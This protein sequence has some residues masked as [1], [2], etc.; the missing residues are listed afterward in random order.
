[1]NGNHPVSVLNIGGNAS[2]IPKNSNDA[3]EGSKVK[4]S[5][6]AK[7]QGLSNEGN[8][9]YNTFLDAIKAKQKNF[10]GEEFE[11][12]LLKNIMDY[13]D[14]CGKN[15]RKEVVEYVTYRHELW[16]IRNI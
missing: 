12:A 2:Q 3:N 8:K 4:G 5:T 1:M 16:N 13:K 14:K 6:C 15:P 11:E 9:K 7:Y 10:G